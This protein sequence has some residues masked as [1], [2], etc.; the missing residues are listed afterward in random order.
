MF[1]RFRR[2]GDKQGMGMLVLQRRR[3]RRGTEGGGY[4][5]MYLCQDF[6]DVLVVVQQR[7]HLRIVA[8]RFV[9]KLPKLPLH[10][11]HRRQWG[12]RSGWWG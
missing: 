6:V 9:E 11:L 12:G 2:A 10:R 8:G 1:V 4:V 3:G 5:G 7:R